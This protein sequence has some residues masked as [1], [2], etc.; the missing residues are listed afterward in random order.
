MSYSILFYVEIIRFNGESDEI[1]IY[2]LPDDII[3]EHSTTLKLCFDSNL[4]AIKGCFKP[5]G[6]QYFY[7]LESG[8][9]IRNVRNVSSDLNG[10]VISIFYSQYGADTQCPTEIYDIHQSNFQIV[11]GKSEGTDNQS[12]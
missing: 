6:N 3:Q 4:A 1:V 12:Q 10:T 7:I 2:P 8:I 9:G 11:Y 5:P